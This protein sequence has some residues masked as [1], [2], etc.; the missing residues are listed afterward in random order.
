MEFSH[1]NIEA[2]WKKIWAERGTYNVEIDLT[3]PKYYILNMFPYPSGAGLHVGHPLGYIASDIFARYKRLKGFNVLNPMGYDSFGLPAEQYAINTGIHPEISTEKNIAR[4]REQLDNIG[5]SF[6][7]RREVRTSNPDFYKWTQWIF[8]Q[9]FN[10]YYSFTENKALPIEQLKIILS[11]EGNINI[12]ASC[13]DDTPTISA[14][15]WNGMDE[16]AQLLFLLKYRL[17][18]PEESFVNWCAK[19]GTVLSNDEVKDGVSERGGY[20]V[21]KKLMKQWSMRIT[22]YADR[23]ISGLDDIDWSASLKE[24]QRNWIGKSQGAQVFFPLEAQN[25]KLKAQSSIEVFTTRVD[26]IF[27]VTFMVLA[28][29]HPLVESLTTAEQ[30]TEI[31]NY[32]NYAKSRSEVERQ[33]EVKKVSGAFTGAYCLNPIS[34]ERIPIYIAD[35][36]LAGYGTGAVMAVPS[37]DQRDWNFAKHFNLP[38]VNVTD[39]QQNVDV[40]ADKTKVGKYINSGFANGLE[41]EAAT[42]VIITWLETHG[43]GKQKTLFRLRNAVFSRQRYWGEP[44]PVYWKD[45][46]PH[47]IKESELPLILPAVDKYLPTETGEPPLAR[48][49]NWKYRLVD[50]CQLTVDSSDKHLSTVNSQLSATYDYE[51][52]TMPG[53]AGSS[54]YWYR[55]MDP[56]N[57]A[58]FAAK[59][60]I[61]YWQNLDLYVGGTEHAVGHL[62]YSRFWNHFL[63]DLGLVP[64]KEYAKKLV[65]QGMIQGRSLFLDLVD[66]SGKYLSTVNAQPSTKRSL[67]VPIEFADESDRLFLKQYEKVILVDNRFEGVSLN[68]IDWKED[69]SGERYVVLRHEVEKMSKSKYNVVNPDDVVEKYGADCFRMYEMFLGPIE[70][71]K[72]WS[73]TGISGVQGFIRKVWSL[74]F[75]EQ[76]TGIR[77]QANNELIHNTS[78]LTPDSPTPEELKILHTCIK[79]VTEDIESFGFNTCISSFMV[80]V[81]GL[82]D[83]KCHKRTILEPFVIMLAPFAPFLCEEL[84]ETLGHSDSVL[85]AQFPIFNPAYLESET[86]LYPISINGKKRGELTVS[87][88]ISQPE[89]DKMVRDLEVVK[90]WTEGTEIKKL[91]IVPNRMI[92]I[93]S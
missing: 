30:K 49:E 27:G 37:G 55:Y 9:L 61:D 13:D 59:E 12:N 28:P 91:I 62:L 35:Y 8:M 79:K 87:K 18:F 25:S 11:A 26:T 80:C 23:L 41:F 43:L 90:K 83:L 34:K 53:W 77:E 31:E 86:V 71:S 5:F 82:K 42:Q 20:P 2:K 65:N 44:L 3:K 76:R 64:Q 15:D 24:Q 84:W 40:A 69:K 57:D 50:G 6:D 92:N 48:A 60:K 85:N 45:G 72:P 16:R 68:D 14:K 22:A 52:S 93:V 29:E 33:S 7:W 47:L 54:W 58:A 74:F 21:E 89:L 36:V 51:H 75:K 4:Y 88:S 38:I 46:V 67:R 32:Q 1:A 63:F 70:Q 73:T 81:N 56:H 10:S 19:L 17:T 39:A 78:L 66:S